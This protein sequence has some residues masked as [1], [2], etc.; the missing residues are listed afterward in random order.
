[1]KKRKVFSF[2]TA[3]VM[4]MAAL[5]MSAVSAEGEFALGDV[6]MDGIITG[7]DSAMISRMLNI[8]PDM[9]TEEQMKLADVNEDGTVDQT[10]LEWIHEN[11]VYEIH[12]LY[13]TGGSISIGCDA[14]Y[15][16]LCYY[17]RKS[18]GDPIE[19]VK[20]DAPKSHPELAN[21]FF[22]YG[23]AE[24]VSQKYLEFYTSQGYTTVAID[25]IDKEEDPDFWNM[26][27]FDS[28][29]DSISELNYNLIDCNGDGEVDGDDAYAA[30]VSFARTQVGKDKYFE[31]GRYD[32]DADWAAAYQQEMTYIEE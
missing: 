8:D 14:A 5:P 6:D 32:L 7:H 26:T 21:G 11:E 16:A 3:A 29:T 15:M 18:V 10:D 20:E 27:H 1:M 22:M 2:L 23:S 19:V 12:D 28:D 24:Y 30:L 4:A 17:A 13:K 31:E 9:L 25:E